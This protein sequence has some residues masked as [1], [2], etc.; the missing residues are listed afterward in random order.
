MLVNKA[1]VDS[2]STGFRAMFFDGRSRA[3]TFWPAYMENI[4]STGAKNTYNISPL[5]VS[6]REWEGDRKIVTERVF[7]YTVTN[8]DWEGT[9][10]IPRNA[11][12]DDNLGV[13]NAKPRQL[14]FE[15]ARHPDKLLAQ[16][17]EGGFVATGA[18]YDGVAF[19]SENH[20]TKS[21]S[22]DRSNLVP[23]NAALTPASFRL[24]RQLLR[25]MKAYNGEP[26]APEMMGMGID[27][28]VPPA[29]ESAAQLIVEADM[30]EGS[31]GGAVSNVDKGKAKVV[32]NPYLTSETGW[33]LIVRG[34]ME[35]P[36]ILQMR[37]TGEL[38]SMTSPNQDGVFYQKRLVWG[39]DGRWNAGYGHF[40][41]AI[42]SKGTG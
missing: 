29:L 32:V 16:M 24:A 34:S 22:N 36:F 37:R 7:D 6:I 2:A 41:M 21:K 19:F 9:F 26:L 31:G 23:S 33:Y 8:K 5:G 35:K 42:G 4:P 13:F 3:Q 1:A 25:G 15:A 17:M 20:L 14:G 40:E 10:Q 30:V 18:G 27:L 12:E 38:V 39:V 28:V 11:F